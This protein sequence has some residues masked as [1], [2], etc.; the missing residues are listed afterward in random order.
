VGF[1]ACVVDAVSAHI[2][3]H[4]AVGHGAAERTAT[5]ERAP[6]P[7]AALERAGGARAAGA[8][9]HDAR[10]AAHAAITIV[11]QVLV[12]TRRPLWRKPAGASNGP[13]AIGALGFLFGTATFG[14]EE[15]HASLSLGTPFASTSS[16]SFAPTDVIVTASGAIRVNKHV[17]LITEN[18]LLPS[19]TYTFGALSGGVRFIAGR[20][21][22]DV[23]GIW[24]GS[25][26]GSVPY[27]VPWLDFTY[28]FGG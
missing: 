10:S 15:A 18:W 28:N 17:A 24:L 8:G 19:A 12:A 22:V 14:N 11:L 7:V 3:I 25:T 6:C 23:G 27:P 21:A 4:L 26:T 5:G 20:I 9:P 2:A 13:A 1:P 16:G